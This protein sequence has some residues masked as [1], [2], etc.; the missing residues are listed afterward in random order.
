MYMAKNMKRKKDNYQKLSI[1]L[2]IVSL[3][4]CI[5]LCYINLLP[6][7]YLFLILIILL[8]FVVFNALCLNLRRL[9]KK[10]KAVIS[11]FTLVGIFIMLV[12][13]FYLGR[14]ILVLNGNG[15]T[16]YKIENYSVIV[17]KDSDYD[18]LKQLKGKK[19]GYYK[20]SMGS[21]QANKKLSKKVDVTYKEYDDLNNLGNGLLDE[22]IDAIVIE[23]SVLEILKEEDQTFSNSIKKIYSFYIQIKT[24]STLKDVNVVKDSFAIYISGIDTYGKISSVSRSDVNIVMVV[25]PSTK[26]ILLISIPRD[27]YVQLH[28]TTGTRDKLAH[29]GIYGIDTS[30]QTVE[31]LLELK[32]NY[33]LKVN[34]TSVIDIVDALNG[35]EVYSDYTF[36][37]YSNFDF[38]EGYNKVNG[39]QAL[40]FARTRKAFVDG[41]RQRGK[42]QQAL[43]DALI[44]KVSSK[45][46]ITKYNSLLSAVDGKYQ[47]NMSTEKIL[48]LIKMQIDDMSP[49]TVTSYSLDGTDSYNYTYT[50]NQLLYVME[51]DESSIIEAK[52]LIKQVLGNDALVDSYKKSNQNLNVV[53]SSKKQYTTDDTNKNEKSLDDEPDED[54]TEIDNDVDIES[55]TIKDNEESNDN[56]VDDSVDDIVDKSVDDTTDDDSDYDVEQN[57]TTDD[58]LLE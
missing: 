7:K 42:N 24:E 53:S 8:V 16:N 13:S 29:A 57:D 30:V 14:T 2:V 54:D 12:I 9:K 52:K 40:D 56:S 26:G 1:V 39:E 48:S 25:N 4:F 23:D 38:K 32:I 17:L 41:D 50:Y 36:T 58:E 27:Y 22:K 6:K 15:A 35:V 28:G 45:A 10:V 33:Y 47:T 3:I 43:I 34:F 19:V 11:F 5:L 44:K 46:I 20:N 21:E 55:D 31:D 18:K 51:P 37:S 49:W